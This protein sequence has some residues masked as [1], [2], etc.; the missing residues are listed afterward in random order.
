MVTH[1]TLDWLCN[2]EVFQINRIPAHSDHN[3]TL[4]GEKSGQSLNGT[5]SFL[6]TER[7]MLRNERI[8]QPDYPIDSLDTIQ[9]PGHIQLQGYDKPHYTNIA[10][11]WDGNYS[12]TAPNIP[13]EFNPVGSYVTD[14]VIDSNIMR[15]ARQYISFQGVESAF[16]LYVNGQFVGYSEDSFTPSEFDITDYICDGKNRIGVEV[17]KWS[18]ASW[19]EDQDFFRMSGIFRDV[20]LY[21]VPEAHV[22]D[23]FI[24]TDVT[25]DFQNCNLHVD[26]DMVFG[27]TN[28]KEDYQYTMILKDMQEEDVLALANV[29]ADTIFGKDFMLS[30]VNLWSAENPY[31]YTLVLTIEKD[32]QEIERIVQKVGMR[33]FEMKDK[34]MLIN[35]KRIEFYGINRHEFNCERGRTVSEEDM[36]WDITFMKQ[37]NINAVRTSHYPNQSRWYELC[38]EYGI[39]V[40]DEVNME[41]HGTW[42]WGDINSVNTCIPGDKPE[43]K[44][45]VLDRANSMVQRDKNHPSVLIWSCGNESYGGS[46]IYEMSEFMRRLDPSRLIHYEGI[47]ADRRYPD[48]SDME[49]RMYDRVW[50]IEK[51]LTNNPPKPFIGCEYSHAMGNSCGGIKNYTDLH[52]YAMYQGSF[53]WDFIDQSL[54]QTLD[55]GRLRFGYGGD[56]DDYPNDGN[57]CGNGIVFADRMVSAKAQEMKFVYQQVHLCPEKTG[58]YIRNKRLFTDTEDLQLVV[59]LLHNGVIIK[60][61]KKDV[62]VQPLCECF[63]PVETQ[64]Y[65]NQPGEYFVQASMILKEDTKWATTG[66]EL[67]TGRSQAYIVAG[68]DTD[69]HSMESMTF[70]SEKIEVVNG[71]QNIGIHRGDEVVFNETATKKNRFN[72][73]FSRIAGNLTSI[74]Y[75]GKELLFRK[76]RLCFYRASTDNDRGCNYM[77]DSGI[78]QFV[79]KRQR[80]IEFQMQQTEQELKIHYTYELPIVTDGR[81]VVEDKRE[82]NSTKE[83]TSNHLSG[84]RA[85]IIYTIY[86]DGRINVKLIYQG[87]KGLPELPLFGMEIPLKKEFEEFSYYGI[88]PME[89]YIDRNQGGKIGIFDNTVT[90]NFSPYLKPQACGN[91]TETRWLSLSD[92]E[93]N[94]MFKASDV[95]KPFQFTALHY[96]ETELEEAPHKEELPMPY[97]TYVKIMPCQMGVGGDNSWG[98]RVEE[99]MRINSEQDIVYEFDILLS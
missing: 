8:L 28:Q 24:H 87:A 97:C 63:V 55:D 77:F 41:T 78:W 82:K 64:E 13:M 69:E 31:L 29:S 37:H 70:Q 5:W 61:W 19:L 80:C 67:M 17:Y 23:L 60:E 14:V 39:Y 96:N 58:I 86:P 9:V 43:W 90:N 46:N 48:T 66:Y 84:I 26:A 22:R 45:A 49:S 54:V 62:V 95:Q 4:Y 89:N 98:A 56:Y 91:R 3:Y 50:D 1:A 53:I 12:V 44:A 16:Y 52:K 75:E 94:I 72:Y 71:R 74:C 83:D 20:Y 68:I 2:P 42:K 15:G 7:P 92:G 59:T 81:F 40:I 36:L 6:Y 65:M 73:L 51:Y 32:G 47:F 11:P 33:R 38:D 88:G 34:L 30:N 35:G 93:H 27:E 76:P 18:S 25:D 99:D 10:Y 21:A 85:E 57:F 79:E